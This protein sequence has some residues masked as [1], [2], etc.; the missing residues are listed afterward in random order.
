ML[1]VKK[2]RGVSVGNE[3]GPGSLGY[4]GRARGPQDI[5]CCGEVGHRRVL[6][7]GWGAGVM[8]LA[9]GCG[10]ETLQ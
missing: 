5:G 2:G 10:H 4:V 6:A 8:G 3:K 9:D 1:G 7:E